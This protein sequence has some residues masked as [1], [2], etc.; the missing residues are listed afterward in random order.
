MN[1]LPYA[2]AVIAGMLAVLNPCGFALLP[3]YIA[4]LVASGEDQG[5]P[6]PG[7]RWRSLRRALSSTVAMT[8]GFVVV[9]AGFGL[10]VTPLA[11]T[12]EPHL[13]WVTVVA[14]LALVALGGWLL[15]GRDISLVLPKPSAGRPVRSLRWAAVYGLSYA[16]ASLSCTIGPFLALVTSALSSTSAAGAVAMFLAYAAGMGLVVAAVSVATALAHDSVA[17]RL[18]RAL[19][20]VTRASGALLVLAGAYVAYYGWF[21]LRVFSGGAPNDP[22]VGAATGIQAELARSLQ[23]LGPGWV[24]AALAVLLTGAAAAALRRAR[25]EGA[26]PSPSPPRT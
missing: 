10:V 21:E 16:V 24:A 6:A 12:V 25:R 7:A 23:E 13:P 20:Y 26:E 9:F 19:P 22:L 8:S 14:G 15:S 11:L 3:G 5:T 1:E 4:L 18:R 17:A 2:I